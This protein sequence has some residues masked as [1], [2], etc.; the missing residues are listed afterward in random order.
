M[1][2]DIEHG[3]LEPGKAALAAAILAEEVDTYLSGF[4]PDLANAMRR[5]LARAA[6][7]RGHFGRLVSRR[8]GHDSYAEKYLALSGHNDEVTRTSAK[9][10]TAGYQT[11]AQEN[12][13]PSVMVRYNRGFSKSDILFAA[14]LLLLAGSVA[15]S[16]DFNRLSAIIGALGE[17]IHDMKFISSASFIAL[18]TFAIMREMIAQNRK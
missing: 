3:E 15:K 1:Q 16:V 2:Y 6:A 4:D 10:L 12:A 11:I 8:L 9:A 7:K 5:R 17:K 14:S 13:T 18:L